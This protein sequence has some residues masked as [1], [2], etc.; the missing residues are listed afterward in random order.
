[1][2]K[3]LIPLF[4]FALVGCRD[5]SPNGT[6]SSSVNGYRIEGSVVDSLDRGI[7][8]VSVEL[9]Y[10]YVFIDSEPPASRQLIVPHSGTVQITIYDMYSTP[11]RN[12]FNGDAGSGEMNIPWDQCDN[13]KRPVGSGLYFYSFSVDNKELVVYPI[14]VDSAL[15]TFTDP[16]GKFAIDDVHF[17]IGATVPRFSSDGKFLGNYLVFNAVNLIFGLPWRSAVHELVLT[18]GRLATVKQTL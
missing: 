7:L 4:C 2:R 15:T 13:F 5:E 14:L 10:T 1:M 16:D 9:A 12:L 17:P 3:I 8:D 6:D 11:V 18:E